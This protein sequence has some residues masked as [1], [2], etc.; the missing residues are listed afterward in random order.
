[1][2]TFRPTSRQKELIEISDGPH[3]V[4]APPGTGK[5]QVLTYRIVHL[6][7]REPAATFRILAL[8]FTTKAAETLRTRIRDRL[9][10]L[11]E[12]VHACNF[13][14][15]CLDVLQHYGDAVD[16]P[17]DTTVYEVDEQRLEVLARALVQDGL[18]V[19]DKKDLRALLERIGVFKRDLRGPEAVDDSDEAAAYEAYNGLLRDYH[20]C[21]FDDLLERTWRLMV[22]QPH[23][24]KHYRR[25]Y[26]HILVDE[27]QDTSRAQYEILR[28]ICGGDHRNVML[29]ADSDQFIY[30]FAGASSEWLDAFVADFGAARHSL[31][32]NFRCAKALIGAANRLVQN[33]PGRLPMALM[34]PAVPADGAVRA[35][36]FEDEEREAMGVADWVEELLTNGLDPSTLYASESPTVRSEDICILCRTRYSLEAVLSEFRQRRI[37]HLFSTGRTLVETPE[38]K[39]VLQALKALQNPADRVARESILAAWVDGALDGDSADVSVPEFFTRLAA[40]SPAAAPYANVLRTAGGDVTSIVRELIRQ[41]DQGSK[42]A[43]STDEQRALALAV[44][45][46]AL[47]ERWKQYSGHTSPTGRTIGGFLGEVALAGKSVIEGPGVRVLTV[48]VAKGLE[49]K[50]VAI[51]GMN[52][53]TF[54]DY[55]NVNRKDDLA[56]ERRIAY[57][58]VTRASRLL[59]LTRPRMRLMPWGDLRAQDESRFIA[60]MGLTMLPR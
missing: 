18:P 20:A 37:E 25:M 54:P 34:T 42:L 58:A 49:F 35:I 55:R 19:P 10:D 51:V 46:S 29:V 22:E 38:G 50:A 45:A 32:E 11:A 39:L 26:R 43:Q 17:H 15:F 5:T 24:A 30:R 2:S 1:M 36:S 14:S 7:E 28:A 27:A 4:T 40:A 44:D 3:L 8:T 57:V 23:V 13:H 48:H 53:G 33:Q 47:A 56:D 16:F 6:L 21:D 41:V 9:G 31:F 60:D 12:R 52:E 59:L